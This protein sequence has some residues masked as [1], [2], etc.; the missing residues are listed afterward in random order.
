MNFLPI[1]FRWREAVSGALG[2]RSDDVVG[3]VPAVERAGVGLDEG[4]E[5]GEGVGGGLRHAWCGGV[6]MWW[7]AIAV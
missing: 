2:H 7:E 6:C 1:V 5:G 3:E 4:E